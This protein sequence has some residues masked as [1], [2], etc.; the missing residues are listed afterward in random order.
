MIQLN[1]VT[2]RYLSQT[3]FQDL[4]FFFGRKER[5]GLVGNNGSGKSTILK[6]VARLVEPDSGSVDIA[7]GTTLGY[8]P[9]EGIAASG[10]TLMEETLSVFGDLLR[11]EE[12]QHLLAEKLQHMA[13]DDPEAEATLERYG[14]LQSIFYLH[15]GFRLEAEAG[16][17]L[18]GLGF[19]PE[20]WSK[21][22]ETFSGGWQMRI[23]L[24][25]LLLQKPNM[26]LLDEPTNHLDLEARNWLET[27]L[28]EYPFS[29][30]VVSHDRFFLDATVERIIDLFGRK[31]ESYSGGY[32]SYLK[33]REN[34]V[35]S[36]KE[37]KR[38]QDEHIEKLETF[39]NK[40]RYKATKAKQVQSRI[41]ELEKIERI[42]LPE[43]RQTI[44]FRFPQPPRSG[45][46][47]LELEGIRKCYGPLCVFQNLD[48]VIE[49]GERVALV[50]PNGAGKSTLMRIMAE[51]D[52]CQAGQFRLGYNTFP[53]YFAQDQEQDLDPRLNVLETLTGAAPM[54]MV[55]HLRSLLGSFL[56]HGD[57]VFKRTTVLSGGERNRLALARI[58]L[59]EANLLLLDEPTNHLDMES[60]EVLLDALKR[61]SGTVVFVSHDRYFI[62]ALATRVLLIGQGR[63][64]SY[65][66][67]YEDFLWKKRQ[68]DENFQTGVKVSDDLR[69]IRMKAVPEEGAVSPEPADSRVTE[70]TTPSSPENAGRGKTV[71]INPQKLQGMRDQVASMEAE[72][73]SLE[74]DIA[75]MEKRMAD[76]DFFKVSENAQKSLRAWEEAKERLKEKTSLWE[77]KSLELEQ[78][79][80]L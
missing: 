6:L 20:D 18:N 55:P 7:K 71:R 62:D 60:K 26:L 30:I 37:A 59:T 25:K 61:F 70:D 63:V 32:S 5:L 47:V 21:P 8:L 29:F 27:Y 40:F 79:S 44:H 31:L 76:A 16:Q 17:I 34:K 77:E 1:S 14:E 54:D 49:Q 46:R 69:A 45:R 43:A 58:L 67:N 72:I 75:R 23:A 3:L 51:R 24:A 10:R 4:S 73:E 78:L 41:K 33:Q 2:K 28:Q 52:E 36:L 50:G 74:T 66:G 65:P 13:Q 19:L 38:R 35:D 56:F 64:E 68:E 22:V 12:E 80:N 9:Q 48:L 57:D 39:I 42:D 11:M 53:A 15:G